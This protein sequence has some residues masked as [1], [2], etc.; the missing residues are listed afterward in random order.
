MK[1]IYFALFLITILLITTKNFAK[2]NKNENTRESIVSYFSGTISFNNN[3]TEKAYEY[4]KKIESN[5][6]N[7]N[8]K[9]IHTLV[10]LKKFKQALVFSK[11]LQKKD[12]SFFEA[13]LLLGLDSFLKED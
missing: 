10:L 7:Y 11:S 12:N 4:L 5:H 2:D 9:Y 3:N 8:I 6:I 13:D 1:N